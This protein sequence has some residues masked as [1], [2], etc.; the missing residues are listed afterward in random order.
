[1]PFPV[2][3]HV[4]PSLSLADVDSNTRTRAHRLGEPSEPWHTP[5]DVTR[6][7][8][9]CAQQHRRCTAHRCHTAMQSGQSGAHDSVAVVR[10]F[11]PVDLDAG[12]YRIAARAHYPARSNKR[13]A[14][15][16]RCHANSAPPRWTLAATGDTVAAMAGGDLAGAAARSATSQ[17]AQSDARDRRAAGAGVRRTPGAAD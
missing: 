7:V 1:M 15:T 5:G 8:R 11:Q 4:S 3:A 16:L 13:S 12:L 9:L 14:V 17:P 10:S 2:S 6:Q